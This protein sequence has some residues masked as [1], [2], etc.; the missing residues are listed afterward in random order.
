MMVFLFFILLFFAV[1]F[2]YT[3]DELY[4]CNSIYVKIGKI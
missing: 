2:F 1:C 3:T 4:I